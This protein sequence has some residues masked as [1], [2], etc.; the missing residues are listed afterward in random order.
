MPQSHA[1]RHQLARWNALSARG[2]LGIAVRRIR[3]RRLMDD[4]M[5]R[6]GVPLE[7]TLLES[8]CNQRATRRRDLDKA[9][10]MGAR[11][12]EQC[13]N[14]GGL[15]M[16]HYARHGLS[17]ADAA[18]LLARGFDPMALDAD[19]HC[20]AHHAFEFHNLPMARWIAEKHPES[21]SRRSVLGAT[22][23][24]LACAEPSGLG[25]CET[26]HRGTFRDWAFAAMPPT[27]R[28]DFLAHAW[29][30]SGLLLRERTY[31]D[32][33]IDLAW[34]AR[35]GERAPATDGAAI[36]AAVDLCDPDIASCARPFFER[37]I[38]ITERAVLRAATDLPSDCP[39]RRAPRSI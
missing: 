11:P 37:A 25:L 27:D 34:L 22:P 23:M 9:A 36:L 10:A 26:E 29:E 39:A 30:R 3:H 38:A 19:G 4:L 31:G 14:R 12:N 6:N 17:S 24:D 21:W 32:C 8:A 1:I 2:K 33:E 35:L 20:F 16:H 15:A 28:D 13:N 7:Q 5:G 18:D